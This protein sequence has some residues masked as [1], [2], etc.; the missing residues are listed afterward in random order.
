[1]TPTS[2]SALISCPAREPSWVPPTNSPSRPGTDVGS[3]AHRAIELW[4]V[5]GD[6][7]WEGAS[8]A[9]TERFVALAGSP[10]ATTARGRLVT[11][12]LR[13]RAD[14]LGAFLNAWEEPEI[15]TE[16]VLVDRQRELWGRADI[17]VDS[18]G[19]IG[20]IEVKTGEHEYVGTTLSSGELRQI[21]FYA[22]LIEYL[23][24]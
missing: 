16:E 18:P 12:R 14:E 11:S 6:W 15:R 4:L 22:H 17:L 23:E 24:A 20:L 2:A 10:R 1:M 13:A 21:L 7:R 9:L 5:S 19:R 8:D 3:L